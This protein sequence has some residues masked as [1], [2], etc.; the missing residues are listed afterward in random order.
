MVK[1]LDKR[2]NEGLITTKLVVLIL[3][4]LVIVFVFVLIFNP[5]LLNALRNQ[6]GYGTPDDRDIAVF[7]DVV[8]PA[9][10]ECPVRVGVIKGVVKI[11]G[12]K[13]G[14][15]EGGYITGIR[16]NRCPSFAK[17]IDESTQ[18]PVCDETNLVP[19]NLFLDG[20]DAQNGIIRIIPLED[21]QPLQRFQAAFGTVESWGMSIG[22]LFARKAGVEDT[23]NYAGITEE[24]WRRDVLVGNIYNGKITL[25]DNLLNGGLD[26]LNHEEVD[27]SKIIN[28]NDPDTRRFLLNLN[29]AEVKGQ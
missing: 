22:S 20:N 9:P 1:K 29:G 23:S 24:A 16:F 18:K 11:G 13:I 15:L 19:F 28:V 3:V 17:I 2:G 5:D 7:K 14:F 8:V 12:V 6:A 21:V 27:L 10:P 25:K 26:T 4:V